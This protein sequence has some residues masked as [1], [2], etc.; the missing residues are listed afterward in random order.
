MAITNCKV[1]GCE[2]EHHAAGLCM[3]HYARMTRGQ[4]YSTPLRGYDRNKPDCCTVEG[5]DKPVRSKGMCGMH[6]VR[7]QRER[8]AA[9]GK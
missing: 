5:C 9:A 1:E 3:G 4:D 2:Y 6:Y 7:S 8:A